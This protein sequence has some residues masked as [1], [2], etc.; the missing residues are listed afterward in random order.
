MPVPLSEP[1]KTWLVVVSQ[2]L[3]GCSLHPPSH[4]LLKFMGQ[5][6]QL[7]K[8]LSRHRKLVVMKWS[9]FANFFVFS[10]VNKITIHA[11]FES[12]W[13]ISRKC[14]INLYDHAVQSQAAKILLYSKSN[15][16][17]FQPYFSMFLCLSDLLR[18]LLCA[19][20]PQNGLQCIPFI[21]VCPL[22][23]LR[24]LI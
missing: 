7:T 22:N 3:K 6:E 23:V 21:G 15:F 19:V 16:V 17:V 13:H 4:W 1:F 11:L 14:I 5:K 9:I 10:M 18:Q 12:T 20:Q 24:K 2:S 8:M